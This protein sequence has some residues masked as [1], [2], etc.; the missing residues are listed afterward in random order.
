M[1]ICVPTYNQP[2]LMRRL[3]DSLVPQVTTDIEIVVR[4][5][6]TNRETEDLIAEYTKRTPI[7][8]SHLE[9]GGLDQAIITLTK[10]ARGTFVWWLGNEAVNEGGV[11]GILAVLKKEPDLDFLYVNSNGETGEMSIRSTESRFLQDRNEVIVTFADLLGFISATIFKREFALSGLHSAEQYIGTAWVNLYLVLHILSQSTKIFFLAQPCF[12]S[13][14]KPPNQS[15]WYDPFEVFAI[16]YVH[17]VRAFNGKF[18][19][20]AL[21]GMIGKTFSSVWRSI[22]VYRAKRYENSF[23]S[24][25]ANVRALFPLYWMFPGFWVAFPFLLMPRPLL[26]VLYRIYKTLYPR[27]SQRFR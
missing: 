5:D 12:S 24:S 25:A 16:N 8:Y 27:T 21:H 14:P 22:L 11:A 1:S 10:E 15:T 26:R 7:R 23:G 2:E 4:D 9:R 19:A 20:H 13:D 3:F 17:I 6:S 18:S